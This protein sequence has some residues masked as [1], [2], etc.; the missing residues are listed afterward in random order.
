MNPAELHA[1]ALALALDRGDKELFARLRKMSPDEVAK[2][3]DELSAK[4]SKTPS[5]FD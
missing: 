1:A 5:L 4:E 3:Y 2:V